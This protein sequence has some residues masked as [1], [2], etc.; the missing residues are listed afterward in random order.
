MYTFEDKL[1]E[2]CPV[3]ESLGGYTLSCSRNPEEGTG[4]QMFG[5]IIGKAGL[6]A[7]GCPTDEK[8]SVPEVAWQCFK[9]TRPA[10]SVKE[11]LSDDVASEVYTT[12]ARRAVAN[13]DLRRA[14]EA[15][16]RA[17]HGG[18]EFMA[19]WRRRGEIHSERAKVAQT[20]DRFDDALAEV[21]LALALRPDELPAL[22]LRAQ[23]LQ[24]TG[25]VAEATLSAKQ[26][27][28]IAEQRLST[29]GRR[30]ARRAFRRIKD[31]CERLLEEL[32]DSPDQALPEG[33]KFGG[34]RTVADAPLAE[35]T[36][37][38]QVSNCGTDE[39]N[40]VYQPSGK[41]SNG[42]PIYENVSGFVLSLEV[43]PMKG[44]KEAR[45]GWIIGKDRL[46]Y[47]GARTD[48]ATR[49]PPKEGWRSFGAGKPPTPSCMVK[50]VFAPSAVTS[51]ARGALGRSD[52]DEV[53]AALC[54]SL[55][56]PRIAG[57]LPE[58]TAVLIELAKVL[59]QVGQLTDAKA[60]VE[61]AVTLSPAHEEAYLLRAEVL[62]AM[63]DPTEAARCLQQ[64]LTMMPASERGSQVLAD[65]APRVSSV[66]EW[67]RYQG[68]VHVPCAAAA[69][70][71]SQRSEEH[72]KLLAEQLRMLWMR[73]RPDKFEN[74]HDEVHVHWVLPEGV[75]GGDLVVAIGV[76]HLSIR[77][78][79]RPLYSQDLSHTVKP[80]ES[81]W[82]YDA[83]DLIL[84]L[85]KGTLNDH[86]LQLK[87]E[88]P[89][90]RELRLQAEQAALEAP[91]PPKA[92]APQPLE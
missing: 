72:D 38:V 71:A 70:T 90:D 81:Y 17:L 8:S 62:E 9:G 58:R 6:P 32:G 34:S 39:C 54:K 89:R 25:E 88:D 26:C 60:K 74:L 79:G 78:A 64:L 21:E 57:S 92:E 19:S 2:G 7:Y 3:Y 82:T 50:S 59:L 35:S 37:G 85:C 63:D 23:L 66:K 5:W 65:L 51:A 36:I 86:W 91:L 75:C 18:P 56:Q 12:E 10:P 29:E 43:L 47:Y 31:D 46:G 20:L 68:D 61:E 84:T 16:G 1:C 67:L 41:E 45:F 27:W 87:Y 69:A 30:D 28:L 33:C 40:G 14:L 24:E 80:S 22:L 42:Q 76:Q 49:K 53:V 13:S 44:S 48:K 77:V 15:Y 11:L 4:R 73:A 55:E 83:P 52:T